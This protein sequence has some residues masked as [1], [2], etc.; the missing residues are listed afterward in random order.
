[1]EDKTAD[2]ASIS[3]L[4]ADINALKHTLRSGSAI[5]AADSTTLTGSKAREPTPT[6]SDFGQMVSVP[7]P[8]IM[9]ANLERA[10]GAAAPAKFPSSTVASSASASSASGVPNSTSAATSSRDAP[11]ALGPILY[12]NSHAP[13]SKSNADVTDDL[14]AHFETRN[15]FPRCCKQCGHFEKFGPYSHMHQQISK[16]EFRCSVPSV[17]RV[18][19]ADQYG[20]WCSCHVCGLFATAELMAELKVKKYRFRKR[21]PAASEESTSSASTASSAPPAAAA[22]RAERKPSSRK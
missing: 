17:E 2:K 7:P 3:A 20:G 6:T 19:L 21:A 13:A 5:R 16:T 18:P 8:G 1:L 14:R 11:L 9:T 15:S 12:P 4:Q 22:V 10:T